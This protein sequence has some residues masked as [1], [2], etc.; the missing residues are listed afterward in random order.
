MLTD[1]V[2]AERLRQ[3]NTEF[4]ELEES[5]HRL[6]LEL[7]ELQRRHVLTPCRRID[8]EA[9]AKRKAGKERQNGRVDPRVS[10]SRVRTPPRIEERRC[11]SDC[12]QQAGQDACR[13]F[14][15]PLAAHIQT[16]KKR[17]IIVGAT[18]LVSLMVAFTFSAE[19]V[20]WLNRPF[21]N[22]AG[23]LWTDGSAVRLD[24][25]VV[26]GGDMASLPV[27]FYQCWK[28]VEP[29][30]LPKE[31]RWGIPLVLLAGALFGLG[32]GFL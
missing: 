13:R 4:R 17:L 21:P 5:H 25:S 19:M 22:P 15:N 16:I 23:V 24:Q 29:A 14:Y 12:R 1:N 20:A 31:Q 26:P 11:G 8:Q 10:R 6:D 7:N 32:L 18:I 3:S 27:I 9:V 28:F 30:L 2:I